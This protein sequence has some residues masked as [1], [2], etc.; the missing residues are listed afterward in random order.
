MPSAGGA[1]APSKRE[2]TSSRC[3]WNRSCSK[4]CCGRRCRRRREGGRAGGRSGTYLPTRGAERQC[5]TSSPQRMWEGW[6]HLWKRRTPGARCQSGSSGNGGSGKRNGR[7]RWRSWVPRGN[8]GAGEELPLFLP[9]PLHGISG[10]GV[11]GGRPFSFV[12]FLCDSLGT[13]R[14]FSWNRPGR[15]AKGELATCRYC[16]DCGQEQ[17]AKCMPP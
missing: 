9:T 2:T 12:T 17:R 11:G 6:C 16:A 4:R 10:R 3:A 14:Y 13:H 15:R 5:W 7:R 8:W 1:S